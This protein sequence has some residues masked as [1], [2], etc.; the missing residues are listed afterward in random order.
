MKKKIYLIWGAA[1]FL[2]L[3]T[4]AQIEKSN[5]LL[6]GTLGFS[7]Y[8]SGSNNMLVLGTN[9]SSSNTSLAP[10]IAYAIGNNSVIGLNL[11]Y[12]YT[13][14]TN[15]TNSTSF[16]S[17]IFYKKYISCQGKFGMYL[18][19][20]GGITFYKY[21]YLTVDSSGSQVKTGSTTR[22]YYA[23]IIPGVYYLVGKKI[24]LEADCGGLSYVYYDYG[25]ED[26][27]SDFSINFLSN[28][29]FGIEFILGK[30]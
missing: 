18:Q 5:W 27:S 2:S 14:S 13:Y 20:N 8:N 12:N 3:N 4:H 6:G 29:T 7:S 30:K 26:W 24:L 22:A 1:I 16:S 11:G 28:F 10:H 17:S 9:S 23:G 15:Q 25:P 19:V 21:T